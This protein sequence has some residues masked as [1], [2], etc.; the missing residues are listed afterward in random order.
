[1]KTRS[2]L[3][4]ACI[5][6]AIFGCQKKEEAPPSIDESSVLAAPSAPMES[7]IP[8]SKSVGNAIADAQ[9][10]P[11]PVHQFVRSADL[12]FRCRSVSQATATIERIV[13]SNGG[14]VE[15][16]DLRCQIQE[17]RIRPFGGDSVLALRR[18]D[19][20]NTMQL[21]V[22][23]DRLDTVLAEIAPLVAF[24][25]HR[26]IRAQNVTQELRRAERDKRR[27]ERASERMQNLVQNPGKVKDLAQVDDLAL[28][29]Q[30]RADAALD[31]TEGL[32]EQVE[33][34]SVQVALY[35]NPEPRTDT[36]QRSL[37]ETWREPFWKHTARAFTDGWMG[38]LDFALWL[39]SHWVVILLLVG[40]IVV[41]RKF[42]KSQRDD[43]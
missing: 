28:D 34:S 29:R 15:L 5:G 23:N 14:F 37:E 38:F 26:T 30:T 35:Q 1:M 21:R 33:L 4:V 10:T 22:P 6:L 42:R 24:L 18:V 27:M 9:R 3:V 16:N 7:E 20:W 2:S 32:R 43:S 39:L 13:A 40:G 17:S 12:R 11:P 8:S 25:D 19:V 31:R 41:F 36:L